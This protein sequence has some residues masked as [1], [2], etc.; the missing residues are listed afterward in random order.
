MKGV[1]ETGVTAADADRVV[2]VAVKPLWQRL[3][4][5][6]ATAVVVGLGVGL[7]V[8]SDMRPGPPVVLRFEY[9]LPDGQAFVRTGRS[10]TALSRDG[11]AFVYQ[12]QGNAL[13]LRTIGELNARLIPGIV[14]PLT[15]PF[16]SPDGQ[17]VG[18][19]DRLAQ[20][21]KRIAISGGAPVT[22]TAA[23]IN[24][25]GVTW[26]LD[27]MILYG[28]E[29]G[30]WQV[31]D[32]GGTPELLIPTGEGERVHGPQMLPGGEWVLFTFLPAG[33]SAWDEAQI[34]VQS[35]TTGERETLIA[36]GEM[37]AMCPQGTW[38]T[39]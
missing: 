9:P 7:V 23:P 17:T 16:F 20:E 36:G 18:Y 24:P 34:V 8:W 21:L 32:T 14:G 29:D 37:P 4:P 22:I 27:G 2:P 30:I 33:T 1:F 19:W 3:L 39:A 28:Q 35:L 31:P 11:R 10:I 25:N 13:Y 5:S 12:T 26:E 15:S 6:V 38:Y